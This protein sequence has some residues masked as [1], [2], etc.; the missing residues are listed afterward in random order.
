MPPV[1]RSEEKRLFSQAMILLE[2]FVEADGIE[3]YVLSLIW[4]RETKSCPDYGISRPALWNNTR[5]KISNFLPTSCV[6]SF[7]KIDIFRLFEND[8]CFLS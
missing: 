1:A 7:G 8:P 6:N 4:G 5:Q 2:Y 3:L